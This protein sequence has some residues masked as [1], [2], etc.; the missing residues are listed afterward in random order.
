MK[1]IKRGY[2]YVKSG[3]RRKIAVI[4]SVVALVEVLA[5]MLVSTS[6]WI[7]SISSIK[8]YTKDGAKG[9]VE[10]ANYQQVNLSNSSAT[11]IDLT[12][13]FRPSGGYHL[14]PASS[15]D[16]DTMY[17]KAAM[18]GSTQMYR[19]GSVSDK[20]VNYVSFTVKTLSNVS[21]SFAQVPT[22]KFDGTALS[23]ANKKLV[24]FSVGDTNGNFTVFSLFDEEFTENVING[25]N[26]TTVASVTV[27]PFSEY[28]TGK[29]RVVETTADGYLS[30]NMWIQDP[31]ASSSSVY[32]NKA[33]TVENF[34]LVT[35]IPFTVKAVTN[36][37][38]DGAGGSVAIENSS[39]AASVT[40]Y[41]SLNQTLSLHAAPSTTNGY[42]FLGWADSAT[43]SVAA[44]SDV[45][46]Y[47]YTVE[48]A[49][50]TLYAKFSNQHE[51]YMKPLYQHSTNNSNVRF[52]AY[53]FGIDSS[54][55]NTH[56]W[57]DMT[58]VTS[59][60]WKGYY[61]C[62]YSGS[63]TNV[64]FC[65]MDGSASANIWDNRWLQTFDLRVPSKN[66]EYGYI[67]TCRAVVGTAR[68]QTISD[69]GT[70]KL[71]GYWRH[72]HAQVAVTYY[73]SYDSGGGSLSCAITDTSCVSGT[74]TWYPED[75]T[76]VNLDGQTYQDVDSN[77]DLIPNQK[78]DKK[79]TLTAQDSSSMDFKG[80]YS[81][82]SATTALSTSHTYEVTAPDN[83]TYTTGT[84]E[85]TNSVTYYAKYE[86][87]PEATINIY[88]TPRYGWSSYY[89]RLWGDG[90]NLYPSGTN[91][92]KQATYDSSTGYYK[93]T[94]TTTSNFSNIKAILA[95]DSSY[96]DQTS[97]LTIGSTSAGATVS[98]RINRNSEVSNIGNYRC[99]WF[100]DNTSGSWLTND[101]NKTDGG[102]T[103]M[104][105]RY[106]NSGINDS[107]YMLRQD[108]GAWICEY[109]GTISSSSYMYFWEVYDNNQ[110][111]DANG[112]RTYFSASQNQYK[113]T[114]GSGHGTYGTG[115][116]G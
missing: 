53:V 37:V 104:R 20:N 31:T 66:G 8:I 1:R 38:V 7:E 14:A 77:G 2:H 52:A 54:G 50:K 110:T 108:N 39:Y 101:W 33:L 72:S 6:A 75:E 86:P 115:N 11:D 107:S 99:I 56:T 13:Y 23:G 16:G 46:P 87:K 84:T 61:K 12:N 57:Y 102:K 28:I 10:S 15:A 91:G 45:D 73:G 29:K 44:N 105:M 96:T 81:S 100:I 74:A 111:Y 27:H 58:A 94:F 36:N 106:N 34:K 97:D 25:E 68:N 40:Y 59:G 3:K 92:F 60:T 65:Y 17:F 5:I 41:T 55:T 98:K 43:G 22:I 89:V 83:P 112:W 79:V 113:A 76:S 80:W 35:V 48:T 9:I 69:Y 78:Y 88:V 85:S 49:G 64:I 103:I 82:T 47:R 90:G 42:Q 95:K 67:V 63:A 19:L 116:N 18:N 30:F 26:G 114:G 51:L 109:N 32:H 62:S 71:F 93:A 21:L 24:R 70:N 4:L